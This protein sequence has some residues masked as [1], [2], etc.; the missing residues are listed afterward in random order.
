MNNFIQ[1]LAKNLQ[2]FKPF[3]YKEELERTVTEIIR[4]CKE[5]TK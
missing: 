3:D 5:K 4:L 2:P 1:S